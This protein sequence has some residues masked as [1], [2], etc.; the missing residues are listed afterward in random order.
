MRS[1]SQNLCLLRVN[2]L[3]VELYLLV[4]VKEKLAVILF[5]GF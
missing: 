1:L 4:E 5:C 2:D 3:N